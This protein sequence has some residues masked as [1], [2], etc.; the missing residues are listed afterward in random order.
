MPHRSRSRSWRLIFLDEVLGE[1]TFLAGSFV[2]GVL[3]VIPIFIFFLG[4]GDDLADGEDEVVF[5]VGGVVK[6][7]FDCEWV[8][9]HGWIIGWVG[10]IYGMG[11]GGW[12]VR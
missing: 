5:V 6:D 1:E 10:V 9:G 8:D 3:S 11:V 7:G 2:V 12:V 4:D